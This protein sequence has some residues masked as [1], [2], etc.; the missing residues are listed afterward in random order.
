VACSLATHRL[1][2]VHRGARG[3]RRAR[4]HVR[5]PGRVQ[6]RGRGWVSHGEW[7]M[8]LGWVKGVYSPVRR[9]GEED[10]SSTCYRRLCILGDEGSIDGETM[11]R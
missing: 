1:D 10:A 11:E 5:E 4:E 9:G 8:G 6:A 3:A 7:L 2:G